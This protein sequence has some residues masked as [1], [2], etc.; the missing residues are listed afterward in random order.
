MVHDAR[1]FAP[2]ERETLQIAGDG[3]GPR[4]P[5]EHFIA[6][7]LGLGACSVPGALVEAFEMIVVDAIPLGSGQRSAVENRDGRV[8]SF[9]H[10]FMSIDKSHLRKL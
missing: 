2:P 7:D 5:A 9:D 6:A 4:S 3:Y 8:V 1:S 10:L